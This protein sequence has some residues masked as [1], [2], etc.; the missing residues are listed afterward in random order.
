MSG[1]INGRVCDTKPEESEDDIFL[2]TVHDVKEV[3]LCNPFDICVEDTSVADYTSFVYSL[4]Y[5][6]DYDRGSKLLSGESVF[7]DKLLV[8]ARDISTRVN[9]CGGVNDF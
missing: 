6:L 1:P 7:P 9:Q 3:F 5:I 2:T 8:Y 4:I